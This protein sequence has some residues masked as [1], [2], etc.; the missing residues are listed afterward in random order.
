[1][2]E[3]AKPSTEVWSRFVA[4]HATGP[5]V[6]GLISAVLPFGAF[7][8]VDGVTGLLPQSAWSQRPGWPSQLKVGSRI[9][10]RVTTIDVTRRRFAAGAA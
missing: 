5:V 6:D 9:P 7:V 3:H 1:M 4:G 10:V 8:E 2:P